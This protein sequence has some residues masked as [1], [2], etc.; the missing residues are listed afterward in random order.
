MEDVVAFW[1]SAGPSKWFA[2]DAAFDAE[3]KGR[4]MAA[5]MAAARRELDAW[6]S[7][8][9]GC[10]ALMI[11]LDQFPRNAFRGTAHMFAT[12]SLALSFARQAHARSYQTRIEQDMQVFLV[13][14]FEHSENMDDQT[15]AVDLCSTLDARTLEFARLHQDIIKRFGRFPHRNAVLGRDTTPEEQRFLEGGDSVGRFGGLD[16]ARSPLS[17]VLY[18]FTSTTDLRVW[19]FQDDR[20]VGSLVRRLPCPD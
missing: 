11:L 1:R 14:P 2:K 17:G 6:L 15:L 18:V 10:L 9:T 4:F 8:P 20:S 5:H 12:D 7:H 3:F 16:F 19:S 13:L